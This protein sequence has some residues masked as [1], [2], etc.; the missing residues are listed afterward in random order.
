MV[1]DLIYSPS[2]DIN[3]CILYSIFFQFDEISHILNN[4]M[5]IFYQGK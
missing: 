3:N 1:V 5:T 2:R 4:L